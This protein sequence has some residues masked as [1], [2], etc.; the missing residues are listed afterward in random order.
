VPDRLLKQL[1]IGGLL[2]VPRG[3]RDTQVMT[4]YTRR[5]EDDFEITT[6]GNFVFVP[7][8]KGIANG[9]EKE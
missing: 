8:L 1:R 5:G 9:S 6:H 3:D 2:V 7:M 4:L